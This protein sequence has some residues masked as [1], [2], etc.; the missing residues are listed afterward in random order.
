MCASPCVCVYMAILR[1]Q[2]CGHCHRSLSCRLTSDIFFPSG[3]FTVPGIDQISASLATIA[4]CTT[5]PIGIAL[6]FTLCTLLDCSSSPP[7][8]KKSSVKS[9]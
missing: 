7:H 2:H 4:L 1:D 3:N 5:G 6:R 8:G 9:V